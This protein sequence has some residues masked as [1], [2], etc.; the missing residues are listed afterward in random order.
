M[1]RQGRSVTESC[2][3]HVRRRKLLGEFV[4]CL[5]FILTICHAYS[6]RNL[7]ICNLA[8]VSNGQH[9]EKV[10]SKRHRSGKQGSNH[11]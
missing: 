3:A 5:F 9:V 8:T 7:D 10:D 6:K 1:S 11:K 2:A 4:Y